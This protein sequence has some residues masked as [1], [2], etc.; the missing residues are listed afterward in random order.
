[1]CE[2]KIKIKKKTVCID[3]IECDMILNKQNIEEAYDLNIHNVFT[4]GRFG[5]IRSPRSEIFNR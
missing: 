5:D 1:M 2:Y 4:T 3:S